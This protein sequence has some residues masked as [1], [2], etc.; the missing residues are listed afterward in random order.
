MQWQPS[1]M[2][3]WL[4]SAVKVFTHR[5]PTVAIWTTFPKMKQYSGIT[6]YDS[7]QR[8]NVWCHNYGEGSTL[9]DRLTWPVGSTNCSIFSILHLFVEN[10]KGQRQYNGNCKKKQYFYTSLS[11]TIILTKLAYKIG[12]LTIPFFS[13][14]F[15]AR[16]F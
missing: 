5:L 13:M 6:S 1:E 3:K 11:I 4:F 10:G 9:V 14:I 2:L 16:T 7:S 8:N 12:C 15:N